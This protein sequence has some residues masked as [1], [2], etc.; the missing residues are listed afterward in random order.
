MVKCLICDGEGT[1][2]LYERVTLCEFHHMNI[3]A[4]ENGFHYYDDEDRN[5]K[6]RIHTNGARS[7][8]AYK[9]IGDLTLIIDINQKKR[10][11]LF[12]NENVMKCR[13]LKNGN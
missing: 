11:C 3:K 13:C 5:R 12:C 7:R 4:T 2:K 9:M 8:I 10:Y 1:E 6:I